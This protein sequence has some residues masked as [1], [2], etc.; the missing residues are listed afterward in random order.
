MRGSRLRTR[1]I[2]GAARHAL[3]RWSVIYNAEKAAAMDKLTAA[4]QAQAILLTEASWEP[5][6]LALRHVRSAA[7][8]DGA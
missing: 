7:T 3:G 4:M 2:S 1:C 6:E 8:T 5:F